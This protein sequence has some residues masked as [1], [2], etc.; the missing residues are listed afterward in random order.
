[1]QV[2]LTGSPYLIYNILSEGM[3]QQFNDLLIVYHMK[4]VPLVQVFLKQ[5]ESHFFLA[6]DLLH[7]LGCQLDES[8]ADL[9]YSSVHESELVLDFFDKLNQLASCLDNIES[10]NQNVSFA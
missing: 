10:D 8:R 3:F 6:R 9:L 2:I 1:M 7:K 4:R 5:V